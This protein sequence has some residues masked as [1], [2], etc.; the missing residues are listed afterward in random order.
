MVLRTL[1][2]DS[3]NSA[4]VVEELKSIDSLS[5][6]ASSRVFQAIFAQHAAAPDSGLSFDLVNARLED[7]DRQLLAEAVLRE[8]SAASHEE[9]TAAIASL[10][11][12]ETEDR[13]KQIKQRIKELE[14]GG[15]WDDALRLTA[16]LQDL[17]RKARGAR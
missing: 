11:R 12:G 14:R 2:L 13:R 10:R 16:E 6:L 3:A 17:E 1:F 9:V 8:D 15:K 4:A 5:R 7:A